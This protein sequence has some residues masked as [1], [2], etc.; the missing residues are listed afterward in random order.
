MDERQRKVIEA[1]EADFSGF[2]DKKT[3]QGFNAHAITFVIINRLITW[4]LKRPDISRFKAISLV[5]SVGSRSVERVIEE[6]LQK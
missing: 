5:W 6:E 4:Y 1:L 3:E 2:L